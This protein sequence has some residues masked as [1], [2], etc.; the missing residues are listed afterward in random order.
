M[1]QQF[2]LTAVKLRLMFGIVVSSRSRE[3]TSECH[4]NIKT[5]GK[6]Y[7]STQLLADRLARSTFNENCPHIRRVKYATPQFQSEAMCKSFI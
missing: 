1:T 5:A 3:S 2:A 6:A 7:Y 4:E